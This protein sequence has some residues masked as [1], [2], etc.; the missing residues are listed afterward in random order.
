MNPSF[1]FLPLL[2]LSLLL[3]APATAQDDRP[4]DSQVLFIISEVRPGT[5]NVGLIWGGDV[6]DRDA[7]MNSLAR[8]AANLGMT[9]YLAEINTLTDLAEQYRQLTREHGVEVLW[10]VDPGKTLDTPQSQRFL[11]ESAT[12]SRV[13]LVAPAATWVQAGAPLTVQKR[14]GSIQLAVNEAAAQAT[15]LTIPEKYSATAEVL[16]SN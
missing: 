6:A 15:S 13:P 4:T 14:D 9:L 8:T 12:K 1:R 5:K 16:A 3:A 10:V 2:L 11:I 7:R